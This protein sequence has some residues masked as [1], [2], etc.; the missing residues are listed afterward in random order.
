M[1][2]ASQER[3][4]AT[5]GF[6]VSRGFCAC[7]DRLWTPVQSSEVHILYLTFA[8]T[9]EHVPERSLGMK[10]VLLACCGKR[11]RKKGDGNMNRDIKSNIE[12]AYVSRS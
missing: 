6:A 7:K 4:D 5:T 11:R 3:Q 10:T 2:I 12:G 1:F 8:A 9:Q